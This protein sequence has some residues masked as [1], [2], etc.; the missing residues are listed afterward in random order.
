M[1]FE[2]IILEHIGKDIYIGIEIPEEHTRQEAVFQNYQILSLEGKE[3]GGSGTCFLCSKEKHKDFLRL[4]MKAT[5]EKSSHLFDLI[6]IE[7]RYQRYFYHIY[8]MNYIDVHNTCLFTDKQE[9]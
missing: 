5:I 6:D 8:I 9:R 2:T 4:E 3:Y 1:E 7:A